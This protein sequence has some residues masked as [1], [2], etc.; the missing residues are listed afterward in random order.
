MEQYTAGTA[1]ELIATFTLA[2]GNATDPGLANVSA[3]IIT[4]EE[5]TID[6]TSSIVRVDFGVY[7]LTYVPTL[8]GLYLYRF[9]STGDTDAA[10]EGSFTVQTSFS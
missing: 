10:N 5:V 7:A 3:E 9:A 2:N 8:N 4:P 6:L 1:I